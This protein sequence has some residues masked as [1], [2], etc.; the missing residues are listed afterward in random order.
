MNK[1]QEAFDYIATAT[2][3]A[4]GMVKQMLVLQELVEKATPK[5]M[6]RADVLICIELLKI[7]YHITDDELNCWVESK[8]NRLEQ[9]LS[10][11]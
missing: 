8:V 5:K 2:N 7:M 1:Y 4:D 9:R 3:G 10:E 11:K 6:E